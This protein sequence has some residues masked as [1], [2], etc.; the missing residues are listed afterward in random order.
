MVLWYIRNSGERH[1]HFSH[2][3]ERNSE[4]FVG[5]PL[6]LLMHVFLAQHRLVYHI[7]INHLFRTFTSVFENTIFPESANADFSFVTP[8]MRIFKFILL[9]FVDQ[10]VEILNACP[11]FASKYLIQFLN[12]WKTIVVGRMKELG[13]KNMWSSWIQCYMSSSWPIRRQHWSLGNSKQTSLI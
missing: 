3:K 1:I 13:Y 2:N 12:Y 9:E 7:Y 6:L 4:D 8:G 5:L 11:Y 10:Y